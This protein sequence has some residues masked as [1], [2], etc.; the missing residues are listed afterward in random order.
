[1]RPNR[2]LIHG[3]DTTRPQ[4]NE[5]RHSS[6]R[7]SPSSSAPSASTPAVFASGG[8]VGLIHRITAAVYSVIS[9]GAGFVKCV[10]PEVSPLEGHVGVSG[11][12]GRSVRVWVLGWGVPSP[13]VRCTGSAR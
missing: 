6:T 2:G 3:I 5:S 13:G 9:E 7:G 4:H 1:M 8:D 10:S 12:R 11:G